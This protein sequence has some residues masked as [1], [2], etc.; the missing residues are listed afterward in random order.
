[1]RNVIK[2]AVKLLFFAKKITK[3]PRGRGLCPQAP[4][5]IRLSCIG[6]LSTRPKIGNFRAKKMFGLSPPFQQNPGCITAS[7][8]QNVIKMA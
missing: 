1:M 4:S 5:V 2:M 7:D 8:V 6:L 3:L